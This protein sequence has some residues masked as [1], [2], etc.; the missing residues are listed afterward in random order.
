[1]ANAWATSVASRSIEYLYAMVIAA[2]MEFSGAVGVGAR[3][4]DTIR[5]KIVDTQQFVD[6]PAVLML[7]M[8]CAVIASSVYLTFATKVGLPV[9]TTHSLMGGVIGF[10]VA[11][12]GVDG[13]QWVMP[14][15]G[16]QAINSGVVQVFMAWIIAPVLAGVFA[17]TIFLITK[18]AVLVR[19]DPV[20]KGLLLVPVYFSVTAS[21]V[22]MLLVWKGGS[23][24]VSLTDA[25]IPMVVVLVGIGFGCLVGV[26]LVPWLYRVIVKED[27][28]LS[29]WHIV[30]GPLLLK[31]GEVPP[32]PTEH[33][34]R[35]RDYYEGHA[36]REDVDAHRADLESRES[37]GSSP[38]A[39]T[40]DKHQVDAAT[41]VGGPRQ[42]KSLVGPK[43]QGPWY[44][45]EMLFWYIKLALFHGVD[46]DVV[47]HQSTGGGLSGN[48]DDMHARAARYDNRAEYLYSFLQIITAATASFTHGAN[49]VS[50]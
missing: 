12:L 46:Q 16:L 43:P 44:S 31:R 33:T 8:V 39:S 15:G 24:E 38:A 25:Q 34:G 30:Q 3:V 26:F 23:Y 49:D 11:A 6:S 36:T 37:A 18:F 32:A 27:W 1:M 42:R 22:V 9:S 13:I 2:I 5:T 17:S 28:Q 14:G 29:W 47:G 19:R 45:G 4:A 48:L 41:S 50:K 7:G 35:V 40:N 20:M 21:L 10:G